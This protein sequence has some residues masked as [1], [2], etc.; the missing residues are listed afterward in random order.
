MT[1]T[2]LLCVGSFFAGCTATMLVIL[3]WACL[4]VG[5]DDDDKS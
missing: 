5:R 3:L 1:N 4:R 2:I